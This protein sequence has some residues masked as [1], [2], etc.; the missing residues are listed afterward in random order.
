MEKSDKLDQVKYGLSKLTVTQQSE[1]V[2]LG[3]KILY[4]NYLSRDRDKDRKDYFLFLEFLHI[5]QAYF[6]VLDF[7]IIN[8][9]FNGVIGIKSAHS[10][11]HLMLKKH[12]TLVLLIFRLLYF[13]KQKEVSTIDKIT[14]TFTEIHEC[15]HAT[16]ILEK[17]IPKTEFLRIIRTMSGFGICDVIGNLS[18]DASIVILYPTILHLL[19]FRTIEELEANLDAFKGGEFDETIDQN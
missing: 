15:L 5:Y 12:E 19:S 11:N 13:R 18:S 2:R 1:F 17:P 16:G 10:S 7:E 6:S 14:T 4:T 3:N 8:D 9:H